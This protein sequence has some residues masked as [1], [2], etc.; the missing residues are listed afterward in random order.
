MKYWYFKGADPFNIYSICW[1]AVWTH[2]FDPLIGT[3]Q[4]RLYDS[5]RW[6]DCWCR[7]IDWPVGST[8]TLA[9]GLEPEINLSWLMDCSTSESQHMLSLEKFYPSSERHWDLLHCPNAGGRAGCIYT[10]TTTM[11]SCTELNW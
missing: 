2:Q 10:G 1:C 9:C 6:F 8:F 11:C 4:F 7:P 5:T 3:S